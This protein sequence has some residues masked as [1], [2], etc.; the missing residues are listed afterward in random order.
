MI[1][2]PAPLP[3]PLA[4]RLP[5]GRLARGFSAAAAASA[6]VVL[7]AASVALAFR[8]GG[9][10]LH[11]TAPVVFAAVLG[12]LAWAWLIGNVQISR[13]FAVALGLLAASAAWAGVSAIWS[14]G[15]DLT[16]VSSDVA[17]LYVVA[18]AVAGLSP[19]GP[20]QLRLLGAGYLALA[21]AV[22]V[23]AFLGKAL[24]EV[25][26]HAHRF[27]RLDKPVGYWNVLALMM[28]M[29][30]PL[31]LELA[32]RRRHA[33]WARALGAAALC[34]VAFTFFF[35]FSRGG[36]IVL[37]V[38]LLVYFALTPERLSSLF[39][40]AA[41]GLPVA[42]VLVHLR[43][44]ATLFNATTNDALRTAQGH[45]LGR[46]SIV[47]LIAAV[48]AQ[49]VGGLVHRRLHR[50]PATLRIVGLAVVVILVVAVGA[51]SQIALASR[52]G[53]LHW[54][55]QRY[56][57]T[58]SGAVVTGN[59]SSRLFSFDT[60]RQPIW[61]EGIEQAR[62][63]P[64]TGTG[65]GT[66]RFTHLLY[67]KS[68]GIV[69]HAHSEWINALSETG[70]IGLALFAA[71]MIALLSCVLRRMRRLRDIPQGAL[72]AAFQAACVAFVVHLSWDWTWDMAAV[73]LAFLVMA[74]TVSGYLAGVRK[75]DPAAAVAPVDA[76]QPEASAAADADADA[77]L[78]GATAADADLGGATVAE[79]DARPR[80]VPALPLRGLAS[81]ILIVLAV[82]WLLPYLGDRAESQAVAAAGRGDLLAAAAD[83]NRAAR[84]DPLSVD[85]LFTEALVQQQLGQVRA[86]LVTLDRAAR[87]QPQNYIVH[88]Q[89]GQLLLGA[90]DR[91][92][93]A[94]AELRLA[95]ALNPLDA[96]V[97][98][99]LAVASQP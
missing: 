2:A 25:V 86:A 12:L 6:V 30:A 47:A 49:I 71:A 99:A 66:F 95:A 56:H 9:Y 83:A 52:G 1:T 61:R 91:V 28:V 65:A 82:G 51:G 67:R 55:S 4:D 88:F 40:L 24:P 41:A 70:I 72:V 58:V 36:Y 43:G 84:F 16:W 74:G 33:L 62:V 29:A 42:A 81:G 23:Y 17:L 22:S 69:V 34:T 21:V 92:P 93:Q 77:D 97:Q 35:T 13:R 19:A 89:L 80:W 94:R 15:P 73:T 76:A 79:I 44:S 20:K 48:V 14:I 46:W 11:L 38:A 37:A 53:V 3:A 63:H 98:A 60:G 8:S 87:L 75:D 57:E 45:V 7:L 54:V 90:F 85:P 59:D 18:L 10:L 78:S 50:R 5:G 39:S 68:G 96:Q 26:T 64:W 27:A 31:A 32:A